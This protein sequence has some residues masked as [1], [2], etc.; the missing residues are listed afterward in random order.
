MAIRPH[1]VYPTD[2]EFYEALSRRDDRA[3]T[4][5]YADVFPSF[6]HWVLTNRGSEMDAEDAFQKGLMSLLLNIESGKYQLQQGTRI[7]TVAFE[8]CKRVWYT[9][10]KSARFRYTDAMPDYLDAA[11]ISHVA[12][13]LE[14]S[15]IWR[16]SSSVK[17]SVL[18]QINGH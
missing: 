2:L 11:D 9:E 3:Y 6:R 17:G 15:T 8:Y 12:G 14:S 4:F 7:T 13:D 1:P 10:L 5:L 16:L 18:S